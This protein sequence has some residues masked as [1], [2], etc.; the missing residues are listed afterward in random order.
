MLSPARL[1]EFRSISRL[2]SKLEKIIHS[3]FKQ[4]AITVLKLELMTNVLKL[5]LM[6]V[7]GYESRKIRLIVDCSTLQHMAYM[8]RDYKRYLQVRHEQDRFIRYQRTKQH[9][10][11]K[12]GKPKIYLRLNLIVNKL[13][14]HLQNQ[15]L[16]SLDQISADHIKMHR[17]RQE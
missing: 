7:G 8:Y 4:L 1:E 12:V 6:T 2:L 9:L 17:L 11:V 13:Q 14:S 10:C 5:Q 3:N 15:L 16:D